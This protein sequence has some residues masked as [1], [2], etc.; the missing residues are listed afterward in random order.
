MPRLRFYPFVLV[1]IVVPLT[2]YVTCITHT[3][4]NQP[5]HTKQLKEKIIKERD[6]TKEKKAGKEDGGKGDNNKNGEF[7]TKKSIVMKIVKSYQ[8]PRTKGVLGERGEE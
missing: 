6:V 4:G 1:C 3:V 7:H 8:G 5:T 2:V